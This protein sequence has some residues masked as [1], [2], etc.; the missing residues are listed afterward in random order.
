M[1]IGYYNGADASQA[2]R[3]GEVQLYSVKKNA[4]QCDAAYDIH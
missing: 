3:A 2:N 1:F 4:L